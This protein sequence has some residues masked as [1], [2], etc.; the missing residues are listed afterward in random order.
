MVDVD[1]V[2]FNP[3]GR[4]GL[5]LGRQILAVITA[6]GVGHPELAHSCTVSQGT[7]P[8]RKDL[9]GGSYGTARPGNSF[10]D[11]SPRGVAVSVG[12]TWRLPPRRTYYVLS[13]KCSDSW[14]YCS[15]RTYY[16]KTFRHCPSAH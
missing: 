6:S 8:Q 15:Q 7:H 10:A 4:Q 16:L 14:D 3:K 9:T 11:D 13:P 5:P 2:R 12:L 1:P